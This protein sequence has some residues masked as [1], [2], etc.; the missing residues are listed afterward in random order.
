MPIALP[1][2][3]T[4]TLRLLLVLLLVA[5]PGCLTRRL[6]EAWPAVE[7]AREVEA[8]RSGEGLTSGPPI[9]PFTDDPRPVIARR[10]AIPCWLARTGIVI[11][12]PLAFAFDCAVGVPLLPVLL[13]LG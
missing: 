1:E 10:S 4:R 13:P 7:P 8:D 12:Y 2:G 3:M 5:M 9:D 11:L 6:I